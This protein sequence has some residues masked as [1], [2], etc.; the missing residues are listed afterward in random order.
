MIKN[1]EN[2]VA[3]IEALGETIGKQKDDI[4]FK[5]VQIKDLTTRLVAAE[6][7][8]EEANKTIVNQKAAIED[9]VKKLESEKTKKLWG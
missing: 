7:E 6:N 1:T 9:F 8:L 3:V 5:E 4:F 2:I